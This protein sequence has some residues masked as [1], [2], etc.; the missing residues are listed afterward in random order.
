MK[1]TN[2]ILETAASNSLKKRK[3]Y[4]FAA[5]FLLF[6]GLSWAFSHLSVVIIVLVGS[7]G[8]VGVAA[9][10]VMRKPLFAWLVLGGFLG[11]VVSTVVLFLLYF[12]VACPL[13]FFIK[14][15]RTAGWKNLA[16]EENTSE[17]PF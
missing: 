13:K 5:L 2:S 15:N 17:N 14:T 4:I 8:L 10:T 16:D 12:L 1:W 11:E 3:Q 6:A 9:P 7:V